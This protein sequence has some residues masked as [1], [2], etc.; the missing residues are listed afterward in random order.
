MPQIP[1]Q[2]ADITADWLNEVLPS[3]IVA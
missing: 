3:D 1:S 2:I